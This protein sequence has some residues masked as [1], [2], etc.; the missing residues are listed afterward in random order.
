MAARG[1]TVPDHLEARV[2][3][4]L[5]ESSRAGARPWSVMTIAAMIVLSITSWLGYER[6][7]LQIGAG[8]HLHCAVIR[9]GITKP[10]GLDK[11]SPEWKPVLAVARAHAP[12]AMLLAVAHECTFEGRRFVHITFRDERHLVS[13]ALTRRGAW[14]RLPVGMHA[15]RVNGLQTAAFETGEFLVYAV[16][17]LSK[18]ENLRL[19]AAIEPD[20]RMALN[21]GE[22][23]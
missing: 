6:S 13:I 9:Q 10:T 20:I 3:R 8:N 4:T 17:D 14:Q 18:Q 7:V 12:D 11:L 2:R 21:K 23:S 16:S 19:L 1:V 5:R 22:K 15:G